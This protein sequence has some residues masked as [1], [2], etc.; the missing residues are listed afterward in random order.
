[1]GNHAIKVVELAKR[2]AS[3]VVQNLFVAPTSDAIVTGEVIQPDVVA[4]ILRDMFRE[5][6]IRTRD[7]IISIGGQTGVVVRVAELPKMTKRELVQAIPFEIERHLPFQAGEVLRDYTILKEPEEVP[8]GGQIPV[9]FAAARGDLVDAYLVVLRQAGLSPIAVEVEPLALSRAFF[10]SQGFQEAGDGADG[11]VSIVVNIGYEGAEISFV[12][13]GVLIFTRLVPIGGRH[14]T[15]DI[16]DHLGMSMEDAERAKIELA[17]AWMEAAPPSA[18]PPIPELTQAPSPEPSVTAPV[19]PSEPAT[20]AVEMPAIDFSLPTAPREPSQEPTIEFSL[21]RQELP[22]AL[23][24]V[25][26]QPAESGL[27]LQVPEEVTAPPTREEVEAPYE[28]EIPVHRLIYDSIHPRLIELAN[29]IARSVEFLA[30]QMPNILVEG[31]YLAGGSS[32]LK[33]LDRFLQEQLGVPVNRLNSFRHM[34]Y[35]PVAARLGKE[36]V[37][38]LAPIYAVAVGLA[39]WAYL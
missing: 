16:R 37:E 15:E 34:D 24:F 25:P 26:T 36:Y 39:L 17:T 14:L 21:D 31:V 5:T 9:L 11:R 1:M 4:G 32:L 8:E 7:A 23:E 29:E 27:T 19:T 13:D 3:F 12:Q 6:G 18:R 35:N 10:A 30:S 20:G 33:D 38:Q 2:G 22:P 28:Y